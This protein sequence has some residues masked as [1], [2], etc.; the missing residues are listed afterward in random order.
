MELRRGD[1]YQFDYKLMVQR[2]RVE[3]INARG[4][5]IMKQDIFLLNDHTWYA[6][7]SKEQAQQIIEEHTWKTTCER[8]GLYVSV[9][10]YK[11]YIKGRTQLGK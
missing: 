8:G 1:T 2:V 6:V 11:E 10:G 5:N 4:V 7:Y 9:N 3:N